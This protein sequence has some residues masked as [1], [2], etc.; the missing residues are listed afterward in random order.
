LIGQVRAIG[1]PSDPAAVT[2][3][4]TVSNTVAT[5]LDTVTLL[6]VAPDTASGLT[7][8]EH[9]TNGDIP[10]ETTV[11]IEFNGQSA[12][13]EY[14]G[15]GTF[16][17]TA[18]TTVVIGTLNPGQ[19]ESYTVEIDLPANTGQIQGYTIP[20]LAFVDNDGSGTFESAAEGVRNFTN[21][22]VYPGFV[23]LI[24][25]A[26]ILDSS[27]NQRFPAASGTFTD[28]FTD[29]L[30]RP[31]PGEFI[32]YRIRYENISEAQP[33]TGAGNVV[34]TATGLTIVEDGNYGTN[35]WA[36]STTH[37][38]NTV[39]KAGTSLEFF[40]GSTTLGTTDPASGTEVTTY[41]NTIPS[42]APQT[43]G[44]FTFRR[45]VD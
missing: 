9:G 14:D 25:D 34:L 26:R 44:A 33:A 36:N 22:R 27:G 8:G 3:T 35:G 6:P 15:A 20:I 11:T 10:N 29:P 5:D 19:Q 2:I 32:E 38:Q 13:Y 21:N 41:H 4:N 30:A 23:S 31:Q 45:V 42:L 17:L 12:T 16:T 43:G 18:G 28:T 7:S 39:V 37:Q 40:D 1:D 24:K